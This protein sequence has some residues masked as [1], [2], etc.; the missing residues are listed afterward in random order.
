[1]TTEQR[2]L[3]VENVEKFGISTYAFTQTMSGAD[4]LYHLADWGVRSVEMML[5]PEHLWIADD[6]DTQQDMLEALDETGITLTSL[7][8]PDIDLNI[9][10]ATEEMRAFSLEQILQFLK[11]ASELNA[12]GL[13]LSPGKADPMFPLP[14]ETL[15]SLFFESLDIILPEAEDCGVEIWMENQP[16]SFLPN[17]AGL[18]DTLDRYGEDSIRICYD[19]ANA[20]F[21]GEDTTAGLELVRERL[22]LVQLS[23]TR[24]AVL[25]HD[26]VGAGDVNFS[27]IPD[28][29][30]A[31][32][33]TRPPVLEII[34]GDPDKDLPHSVAALA[35]MG[36]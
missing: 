9:A 34:T 33:Y 5:Y 17:A 21:I 4:C 1:M 6:D 28:A 27:R 12:E 22:A 10:A 18:M 7:T 35:G 36:F 11:M 23:D 30:A 3:K 2:A 32:G 25:R 20:H 29:L 16:F 24:R 14:N 15:E 8:V 13:I 19:I 31:A 26:P